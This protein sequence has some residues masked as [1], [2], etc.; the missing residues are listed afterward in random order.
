[1]ETGA[2]RE[3]LKKLLDE[4][5]FTHSISVEITAA[6]LAKSHKINV[7]KAAVAGLLHDCARWMDEAN[8]LNTAKKAYIK[9]D[10]FLR[11][12]PKLLHSE[13]STYFA[14]DYFGIKDKE[15]LTAI[16]N[17]TIGRPNMSKLE[18]IIYIADHVEPGRGHEGIKEIRKIA[19]KNLNLAI[20]KISTGMIQYLLDRNLPIYLQT[21]IT[22]N[23][24][25][26]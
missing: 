14:K 11:A 19:Y 10:P 17:H 22:R 9:I 12:H 26:K 4:E 13:L 25:I 8:L 7:K 24:Y 21:I 23:Y 3:K 1:M 18:K 20:V 2:L 15:I 16:K 6:K 5:R